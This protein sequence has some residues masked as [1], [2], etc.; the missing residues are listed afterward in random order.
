MS[1]KIDIDS[2]A[3][4]SDAVITPK[5]ALD[6]SAKVD[7]IFA[8]IVTIAIILEL[9]IVLAN[10]IAR[11]FFSFSLVWAEEVGRLSLLVMAFI[12]GA[13]AYNRK[14][15]MAMK[16]IV[17]HLST[18]KQ[19]ICEA[20]GDWL[21]LIMGLAG[22]VL[23]QKMAM[24]R[25]LEI[26]PM[27]RIHEAW[28]ILPVIVGMLL[29]CFFA[30]N[31]LRNQKRQSVMIAGVI[32][33]AALAVILG[34]YLLWGTL[35]RTILL[36]L[37]LVIFFILLIIGLPI[38]FVLVLSS[39]LYILL[40][41]KIPLTAIPHA[42]QVS[43]GSFI[44][45]A[46]PFFM[47]AGFIMTEGGLSRRIADFV[48]AVIGQ[49]RG[50][51]LYVIVI[52][53]YI[54]SGLS[55]SK[56]ADVAAVG[57]SMADVLD[58]HGYKRGETSA[59]L[60]SSA[61]MGETVPPCLCLLVLASNTTLSVGSLFIAGIIPAALIGICIMSL[62]YFRA[63]RQGMTRGPRVSLKEKTTK[64]LHA[65]P[66]LIALVILVGGVISGFATP[67]EVSTAAVVYALV[68]SVFYREMNLSKCWHMME[69]ASIMTAM[70]LFIICAGS[71]FS[72]TL[73]VAR[74]PHELAALLGLFHGSPILFMIFSIIILVPM[75]AM[76]EGLPA[77]LIFGP[78]LVPVAGQ[79]GISPLQYG[80]FLI[81]ALGIGVFLPPVGMG[82][83]FC[84]AILKTTI[85]DTSRHMVPYILV[86]II[87][88]LLIAFVPWFSLVLPRALHVI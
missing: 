69:E 34:Y 64:T 77:V 27:L 3:A 53:T 73:T 57:T 80:I 38:A 32:L 88:L 74:L 84:S 72:W 20:L 2:C 86:I 37:T 83:Y 17:S 16:V 75:G 31:N 52:F 70:V 71:A 33:I 26:T 85:E 14:G 41:G 60:A 21:V 10:I 7:K 50:G 44:L 8:S 47:L 56:L 51:L 23:A 54:V 65:I 36:G 1:D 39:L 9:V 58:K 22:C 66:A 67:T 63:L 15:H 40:V 24:M 45:L 29:F 76:L 79:F 13:I 61:I 82:A 12:G 43:M 48:T 62:I 46:I 55:G 87:G 4:G 35:D 19:S 78:L 6:I 18:Y 28:F 11:N 59:V 42:M 68:L 30:L 81:M 25:W 5:K 49:L